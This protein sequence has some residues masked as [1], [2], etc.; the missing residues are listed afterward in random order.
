MFDLTSSIEKRNRAIFLFLIFFILLFSGFHPDIG[1]EMNSREPWSY[2]DSPVWQASYE[3]DQILPAEYHPVYVLI[4]GES[5]ETTEHNTLDMSVFRDVTSRHDQILADESISSYFD[6]DFNSMVLHNTTTGP[7]GIAETVRNIMDKES[8]L[9][10]PEQNG[11]INYT[12]PDFLDAT[13]QDLT[14]VLNHLMN[15]RRDDGTYWARGLISPDLCILSSDS[16]CTVPYDTSGEISLSSPFPVRMI[17]QYGELWKAKGFW[18]VA[19][20]NSTRLFSDY[21][22]TADSDKPYYELWYENNIFK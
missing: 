2:P 10:L 6:H 3:S 5:E 15:L 19:Q 21:S 4:M 20:A 17:A 22:L 18:V 13:N 14:Y 1:R 12:G 7:W 8:P 11:G 9:H 16:G